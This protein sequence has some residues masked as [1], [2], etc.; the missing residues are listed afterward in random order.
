MDKVEAMNAAAGVKAEQKPEEAGEEAAA[1]GIDLE[2]K[3]QITYDDF[4]K[5]SS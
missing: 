1:A 3:P 5:L 4:A 2:A